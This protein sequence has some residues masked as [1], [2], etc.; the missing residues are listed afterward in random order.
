[1][2]ENSGI[3]V[4]GDNS[5]VVAYNTGSGDVTA[6]VNVPHDPQL[7]GKLARIDELLDALQAS[8][9]QLPQEQAEMLVEEA[10]VLK[11]EVHRGRL[12]PEHIRRALRNL[13]VAAAPV[14]S[15]LAQANEVKDLVTSLLH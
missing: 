2:Q 14:F 8:A 12:S 6:S 15:I 7:A 5:G 11:T 9:A 3:F 4:G 10:G 1:M 13:T